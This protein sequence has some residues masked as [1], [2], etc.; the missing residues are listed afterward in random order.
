[1]PYDRNADLPKGVKG[2]LPESA[3]DIWR[4]AFNSAYEQYKEDSKA[5]AVAWTALQSAGWHK[6]GDKWVKKDLTIA[7]T[8]PDENL[9]FGWAYV[10]VEKD[11]QIIL[12]HSDEV[13]DIEDLE[14]AA[15]A[16]NLQFR[17]TGEL[18][19]GESVGQLVESFII[20]PA[21]LEAMGLEKDALPL[22]WWL[23]FHVEDDEVFEKIKKGEYAMFS[24][25]GIATREEA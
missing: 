19:K 13:I 21:K 10:S 7:K 16:F 18:H 2:N 11:G 3:Q 20:T 9:V 1:M 24:I 8:I 12:D 14:Y 17:E 15:Y 6:E 23:G 5:S 25:Q 4:R 22:G